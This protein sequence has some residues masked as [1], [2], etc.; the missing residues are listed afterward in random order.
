MCR[1]SLPEA[2]SGQVSEDDP[3]SAGA[4]IIPAEG[5]PEHERKNTDDGQR[6][7]AGIPAVEVIAHPAFFIFIM[8]TEAFCERIPEGIGYL[9]SAVELNADGAKHLGCGQKIVYR[10]EDGG[11]DFWMGADDQWIK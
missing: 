1:A 6:N 10:M 8:K 11:I 3:D 9:F 2:E 5:G 7:Y 4:G